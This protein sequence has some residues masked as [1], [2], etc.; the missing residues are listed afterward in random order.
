MTTQRDS[1]DI[2]AD[3]DAETGLGA[4]LQRSLLSSI[5]ERRTHRVSRGSTVESGSLSW[6]S[7]EPRTPLTDLEEAVLISITGCTG[8]TMPDR[9]LADPR[10][11]KPIMAKPNLTMPGRTAGSPDNAQGT[12]FF[13]INDTG[14]YFLRKL[15]PPAGEQASVFDETTLLARAAESKVKLLDHRLDVG[16]GDR[17]FPAYLDSNR[18]LSNLPG[19]TIL[20]PVVD[21]SRQYINGM[22]YLLTQPEGARPTIVD[23]RN[24]YRMAGVKKWVE[25]GF[26]NKDIKLPLG[27]IWAMRTQIEADLLLQNLMLTADA[28]GLGAWIHCYRRRRWT[29]C[30]SRDLQPPRH[31]YRPCPRPRRRRRFPSRNSG[32]AGSH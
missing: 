3:A 29:C 32:P 27:T 26:L 13:L 15:P 6:T 18:F 20:F 28:M 4:L 5:W 21:L 14:T 23:D 9:P 8:L 30:W 24:F 16:D 10:D 31:R 22:M 1:T 2:G 11:G 19:T 12:H 25:S 7:K 17:D